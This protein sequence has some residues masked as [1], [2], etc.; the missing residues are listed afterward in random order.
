[1]S[2]MYGLTVRPTEDWEGKTGFV[3]RQVD[4]PVLDEAKNPTDAEWVIIKPHFTGVCGSDRGIWFRQSFGDVIKESLA[5]EQK[6]TRV[7][8]H[9]VFGEIVAAGSK[10]TERFG[11]KVGD[12][13]SAESHLTCNACYQCLREEKNVCTNEL[14]M[15]ISIDGCFAEYLKLPADVVWP[16]NTELIR[17]EIACMQEPF[18]NAVHAATKVDLRDKTVAVLGCGPIGL[19]SILIARAYGARLIIAVDPNE[20][21]RKLA[22]QFGANHSLTTNAPKEALFDQELVAQLKDLTQGVGVDVSMEMAG[23]HSSVNNAI[24]AVRRGGDVILFGLK[25]GPATIADFDRM[26]IRGITLHCIIGRQIFKTWHTTRAL[27]E[28]HS[29]GIQDSLWKHM[30]KEGQGTIVDFADYDPAVFAQKMAE[31]PKIIVRY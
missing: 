24:Q 17:P 4:Q 29:N 23:F 13:V 22:E 26:I 11:L 25:S 8:G 1:M 18:G 15:G 6:D 20:E 5:R 31:H 12:M 28:D 2:S 16:T 19:F 21:N 7:I 9:E 10:A 3:K 30:L 27:M 14:I